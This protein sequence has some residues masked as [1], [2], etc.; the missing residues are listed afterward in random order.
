MY[1]L[2]TL[3]VFSILFATLSLAHPKHEV[4]AVWLTTA[5]GL[6][7]PH[8]PAN[9]PQ[10]IQ[11]QK[12]ELCEILDVLQ[13]AHFNT[14]LLQTRIRGDV[15][16]PSRIETWNQIFTGKEGK[17]PGYDPLAYAIEE[18]HKRGM[19][20]HAWIVT[21]PLGSDKHVQ[22]IGKESVPNRHP[23]LCKLHQKEWYLDPG[24]PATKVYL[25]ALIKEIVTRYDID[26]IH[27]DY[28]R[29]PD[30]PQAFPDK[31]TYHKYAKGIPIAQWRR[32]NITDIVR[33]LYQEIK[34]I[35]PWIKVSS[36]P[37]GKFKDT[38]RYSSLGWN[39]Y[40]TVFQDAQRWMK[41]GIQDIIFPMMY[42]KG[43]GFFPFALDWQEKCYGRYVVP[44]L[45]IYFPVSYTH[46]TL[47][48]KRI[49]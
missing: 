13:A 4:R 31:D 42:F 49:V 33:K 5:Y 24:N 15:I 3:S 14:V 38:A 16:Y 22:R 44:G 6:D 17:Y 10:S 27:L 28:I 21:I 20:L 1:R 2:F 43:N 19:E 18:C 48:S 36:S 46:L 45:G 25:A 32:N 8:T 41:E 35:K 11:R 12:K 23:S 26:G 47:P 30:R 7:W 40:H 9:G 34:S 29:Y 37:L 39:G